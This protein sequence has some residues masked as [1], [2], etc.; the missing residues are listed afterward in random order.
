MLFLWQEE[1]GR[2]YYRFQTDEKTLADKMKRREKFKLV[3][4]GFNCNLWIFQATFSRPDIARKTF[5]TLEG[6][7]AI[8][9]EKEEIFQCSSILSNTENS[10]A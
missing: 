3:A 4:N 8:F 1:R 9:N 6:Q 7:N 2:P 10:A 5:K